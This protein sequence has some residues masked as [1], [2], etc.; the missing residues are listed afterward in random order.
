MQAQKTW[1][2][3]TG[4]LAKLLDEAR[5]RSD[6]LERRRADLKALAADTPA[7]P[8]FADALRRPDVAVIAEV[9]RASPSKGAINPGVS[10][11]Q[12]AGAF[13]EGGAA[14][15][16]ILTEPDHFKG[17]IQDLVDVRRK[18][19]LPTLKKDFHVD[20]IQLL[21]ARAVGA[22]AVLLIARALEPAKLADLAGEAVQLGL[23]VLVEVRDEDEL[24]RAVALGAGAAPIIGVNNR[25]LETLVVSPA[26]AERLLPLIPADRIA[27]HESGIAER[28]QVE[29]AATRGADAVLVGS[30]ISAAP[31]PVEAVRALAGVARRGRGA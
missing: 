27:V 9:K 11:P 25:N 26:T 6:L 15:L 4:T 29:V 22:S 3:P 21:E 31:D 17:T 13:A 16:S 2:P 24:G 14:A 12:L 30:S 10:A 5:Q 28:A 19:P 7:G 20:A 23:E 8:A 1:R 18:V